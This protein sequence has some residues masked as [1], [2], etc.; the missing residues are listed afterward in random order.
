MVTNYWSNQIMKARARVYRCTCPQHT[1]VSCVLDRI[2]VQLGDSVTYI[3]YCCL[4]RWNCQAY[5]A[6]Y[7]WIIGWSTVWTV[8]NWIYVDC[9]T[10]TTYR[11]FFTYTTFANIYIYIIYNTCNTIV[12]FRRVINGQ[13]NLL[14]PATVVLPLG[15][16]SLQ[17]I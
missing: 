3:S 4:F 13:L 16:I 6:L 14:G 9:F 17:H 12:M 10:Y 8:L 2:S 15:Q 5:K 7:C 1:A 11:S